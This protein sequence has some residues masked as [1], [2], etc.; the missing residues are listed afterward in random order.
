MDTISPHVVVVRYVLRVAIVD[1]SCTSGL[2][3]LAVLG[4]LPTDAVGCL[5]DS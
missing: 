4:R 3:I 5:L 1:E 2:L